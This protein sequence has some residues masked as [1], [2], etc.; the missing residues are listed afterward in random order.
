VK[1]EY[2]LSHDRIEEFANRVPSTDEENDVRQLSRE[3]LLI[4][5]RLE[6]AM[7]KLA[8]RKEPA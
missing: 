5:N 7:R 2:Y 4:E 8:R 3:F 6:R 1:P